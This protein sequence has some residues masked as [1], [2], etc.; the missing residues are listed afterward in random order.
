MYTY[1]YMYIC[2]YIYIHI[3]YIQMYYVHR[4]G[5]VYIL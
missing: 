5:Y 1:I 2:V 4:L 3:T